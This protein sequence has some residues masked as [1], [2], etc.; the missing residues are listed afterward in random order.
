MTYD[1]RALL[2]DEARSFLDGGRFEMLVGGRLVAS[3]SGATLP[4]EDPA[5]GAVLGE[6]PA[7]DAQ[8]V[9][10][11]VT[12]A[13]A[14]LAAPEWRR[15]AAAERSRRLEA[16]ADLLERSAAA[17]AELD[18][19]DSG[20]P[21]AAAAAYDIP[22]A[23]AWFRY[24]AGWPTKILGDT[25]PGPSADRLVY[26]VRQPVGVVG[27][28][29][30][31]NFPLMMA[32]WKLAP[33]LAAG[34]AVVL[35]P[36]EQT[37]LS[38]LYLARLL[39]E[40]ELLPPGVVNIVT[41]YGH[42]AGAALVEHP[43]VAKI[44]FTGS[45]ATA[46][47]IVRGSASGLKRLT[48]ELGGKSPN[49]VLAD[50]DPAVAAAQAADAAFLNQGENCCAGTRLY[51]HRDRFDDVLA[52][53]CER[54]GAVTLGPGLHPDTAMGPLVS[55]AQHDRVMAYVEDGAG[56]LVQGG[57]GSLATLPDGYFVEPTVFADPPDSSP[58]A[59]EEVFGP[60]LVASPFDTLEEVAARANDTDYGLAAGIWTQDIG[61][62]HRLASLIDAGTVWINTYN[63]TDPAVPFGGFKASGYGR[64]HGSQV[65]EH[66][67]ETK[68]VWV[69]LA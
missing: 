4:V 35:K 32:A 7:G 10:A 30:P 12:A 15:M 43:G 47:Q 63:E 2:G 39:A 8:D 37:P 33:A 3:R 26:T 56:E 22:N 45:R 55:R 25:I 14:A 50:V 62:A 29:I 36:A 61:A 53:V 44:A 65:L 1:H 54:A 18:S 66:Y 28:I 9:D 52:G 20:K 24:F 13:A 27:Q 48:L 51:V 38:A 46:E 17:M 16:V 11:A 42:Q 57:S 23:I 69:N 5:T 64:E 49:I 31:W 58:I 34:C 19:L 60:V 6:V 40:S 41:G 21:L 68:A 67:L 59:R